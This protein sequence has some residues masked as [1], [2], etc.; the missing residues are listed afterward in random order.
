MLMSTL[1]GF[2]RDFGNSNGF[3]ELIIQVNQEGWL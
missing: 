1:A 3:E 2:E